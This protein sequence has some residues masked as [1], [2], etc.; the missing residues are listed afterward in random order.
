MLCSK[1]LF[2]IKKNDVWV[3]LRSTGRQKGKKKG[4]LR[5]KVK[6]LENGVHVFE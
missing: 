5:L 3:I 1:G 2:K 4:V 6:R